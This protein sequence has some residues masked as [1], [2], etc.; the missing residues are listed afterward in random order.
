[1]PARLA[2]EVMPSVRNGS[3]AATVQIEALSTGAPAVP[4]AASGAGQGMRLLAHVAGIGDVVVG[5]D[6][7]VGGPLAPSR[8]E[9]FALDWADKPAGV[10]LRYAVRSGRAQ[11]PIGQA[12]AAGTFAGSRG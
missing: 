12:V 2:V 4:R 5:A 11:G 1:A 7:W 8:I 3:T 6:E 10:S 9:G